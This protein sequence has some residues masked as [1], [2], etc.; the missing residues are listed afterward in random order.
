M[1]E[2]FTIVDTSFGDRVRIEMH[3][4][5]MYLPERFAKMLND[6]K[7]KKLNELTITM[8]HK[9]K[10]SNSNNRLILDFDV[11]KLGDDTITAERLEMEEIK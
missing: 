3:D 6:E 9:G 4:C 8:A 7:V 1:I 11:I 2:T 10:D 5:F